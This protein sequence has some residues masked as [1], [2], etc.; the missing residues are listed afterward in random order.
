MFMLPLLLLFLLLPRICS[1]SSS[2][3]SSR[4]S[5]PEEDSAFSSDDIIIGAFVSLQAMI[6]QF[7]NFTRHPYFKPGLISFNNYMNIL[8][9]HFAVNEINKNPSLLFNHSLGLEIYDNYF[10]ETKSYWNTLSLLSGT[11]FFLPNYNCDRK[12]KV[13][14][15][16]G[17]GSS[18]I[19][20]EMARIS[21][22]YKIPQLS[23]GSFDPVLSD[24]AQFPHFFRMLPKEKTQQ[25]G[26][27]ELLKC[28]GWSWIG[29][30]IGDNDSGDRFLRT[31]RPRLLQSNIC[32][33][34]THIISTAGFY[35]GTHPMTGF[36][37]VASNLIEK[38]I[39]VVI[40]HG[41]VHF[42]LGLGVFLMHSEF[43]S[44]EH[45]W[46]VWIT[47]AQ[48]EITS[49]F[50]TIP[51]PVKSFN[52]TLC[53]IPHKKPM[54][55]FHNFIKSISPFHSEF[56]L[57]HYTWCIIFHCCLPKYC[58]CNFT[59]KICTGKERLL[60]LPE[61]EFEKRVYSQS[62]SIYNAVYVVMHALQT[63]YS[64]SGPY[65]RTG[66][67]D[68]GNL[69]N[70]QPWQLHSSL[71]HTRF[72]NTAGEEIFF[73]E[74]GDLATGYDIINLVTFSPSSFQKVQVGQVDPQAPAGKEFILNTSVIVWNPKFK[75]NEILKFWRVSL[76]APF[77]F[78]LLFDQNGIIK[79]R[80][81]NRYQVPPEREYRIMALQKCLET[82]TNSPLPDA[83]QCDK[84]PEDQ[85]PNQEQ[86]QCLRKTVTYLSY[87]EAL[88][89]VLASLALFLSLICMVVTGTFLLH[90]DTPL[91]K[92]NNRSITCALLASLLLGFLCCFLF[93]GK[94]GKATCLLRQVLFAI[95]FSLSVSCVLGKTLTVVVAFMATK[96]G[97]KMRT[98]VGKG[99]GVSSI[100]L[101]SLA[102]AG[103]CAVWLAS[104][105]P[106]PESD[107]HSQAAVITV[108]C[109]EGLSVM[110]YIVLGYMGLL[111]TI[112]FIVAFY[113]RRLPS[114]FNEAKLITFSMLVFCMVWVSFVPTYLSTSGKSI[115]AVEIFS[116][117]AS[118]ACLLGF[119]FLPK[120]YIIILRPELN[121]REQVV[122][123]TR[124]ISKI[125]HESN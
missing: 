84:C 57:I 52:G 54:P 124:K 27:A 59:K 38:K 118:N 93:I 41:E 11:H 34:L 87:T 75:Q 36:A 89:M 42:M 110:F 70:L 72:N 85:Y 6:I 7:L 123:K 35:K 82:P 116:I 2:S 90:W 21:M 17:G 46:R 28:L 56:Y 117:L 77:L 105:P 68:R 106:F 67:R 50:V 92:A 37:S 49:A 65:Q 10:L 48:L 115:V 74:N 61:M 103:I 120:C 98:W 26:I 94:P 51:W 23:Y 1:K 99:L 44:M 73:D 107:M 97:N 109:N 113:A 24:K 19:S 15:I 43:N 86:I 16:V 95:T 53:F 88:G 111:A 78:K 100:I 69:L 79:R 62:Y 22:A 83:D 101:C 9:F 114:S 71:R 121:T 18:L 14:A 32:I 108:Q 33:A 58:S 64:L 8:A 55:G 39:N 66:A 3:I 125:C 25:V 81:K 91:V 96:P 76:S 122:K 104:F 63:I 45:F 29:L 47:T 20:I 40:L 4:Q 5:L 30:I 80:R 31:L 119:I 12:K 112:S 102:Q 13:M 60:N